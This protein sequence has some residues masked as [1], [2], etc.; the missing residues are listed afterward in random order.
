MLYPINFDVTLP[1]ISSLAARGIP[2][3]KHRTTTRALPRETKD[4]VQAG[5]L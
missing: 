1:L 4:E 5:T 3:R 2:E